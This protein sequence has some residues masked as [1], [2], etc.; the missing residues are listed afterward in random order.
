MYFTII[1]VTTTSSDA[2]P[3]ESNEDKDLKVSK[4]DKQ[5][6]RHESFRVDVQA[7][8]K[9]DDCLDNNKPSSSG[10]P[11]ENVDDTRLDPLREAKQMEENDR[12]QATPIAVISPRTEA[13]M[14]SS[15]MHNS[16]E[17]SSTKHEVC[18]FYQQMFE[19]SF[20]LRIGAILPT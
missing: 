9:S 19:S 10:Q 3:S 20:V 13:G 4:N 16:V 5:S 14:A 12:N 15:S 2:K 11:L 1:L 7:E 17:T 6:R 18:N 8:D